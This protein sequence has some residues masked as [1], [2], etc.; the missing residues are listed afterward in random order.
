MFSVPATGHVVRARPTTGSDRGKRDLT[1]LVRK[2]EKGKQQKG[3]VIQGWKQSN[4]QK[5]L[6]NFESAQPSKS[7]QYSAGA[8]NLRSD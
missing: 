5:L 4:Q 7:A 3:I 6:V 2:K 8:N 1:F